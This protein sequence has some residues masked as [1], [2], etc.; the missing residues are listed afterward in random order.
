M[1]TL[2]SNIELVGFKEV[3]PGSMVIVRK[4]VGN[5]FRRFTDTKGGIE[6]L[7]LTLK[8]V[9]AQDENSKFELK[10][11]VA[12]SGAVKASEATEKNLFF[13]LDKVLSRI[14]AQL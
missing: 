1:I 14:E 5:Y 12:M 7:T 2:G 11:R 10:G 9:H 13:A 4:M 6:K 8:P 3:D